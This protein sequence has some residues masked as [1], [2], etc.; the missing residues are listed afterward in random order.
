[1]RIEHFKPND[2]DVMKT[3]VELDDELAAKVEKTGNLLHQKPDIILRLAIE[4]GLP[5]LVSRSEPKR[6][7]GYFAEDYPLPQEQLEMEAA[8]AKAEQRPDR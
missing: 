8:M 1:M 5:L 3:S 2:D 7:D 6:P 4:A